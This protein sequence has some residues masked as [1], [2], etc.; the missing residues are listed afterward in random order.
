VERRVVKLLVLTFYYEPDLSAG[1]FRTTALVQ[2][3]LAAVPPG[4]TI[5]VVTTLPNR[6]RSFNADA[7][8][9]EQHGALTVRRIALPPHRSGMFDQSNSFLAFARGALA[10]TRG[11]RYELVFATSS[12]LMTAALGAWIA[13]R[14]RARLYLDIRDIFADTIKDVAPPLVASAM[15]P[16]FSMLE[17]WTITRAAK[18][19]LVS[20]GFAPYFDA[21]YPR[22]R[23]SYFTNG[24][25]DEF[26]AIAP[27]PTVG[28]VTD[29][30]RRGPLTVVYA[31]N[32][33]K[34]QGLHA[35]LPALAKRLEGRVRFRVIGDGGM[36][37]ALAAALA[38]ARVT[39]VELTAPV[40]REA[41]INAYRDADVLF[42]HLN[43]HDAFRKV[44]PSK[45]FEY[46]AMGKPIWAGVAGYAAGFIA[47]EVSN[48]A[49]FPP[50]N[51]EGAISAFESLHIGDS[52]RSEFLQRHA[53]S[54]ISRDLAADVIA[55][56]EAR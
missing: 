9:V 14:A 55:V 8:E 21:R 27:A 10:L 32:V 5:D 25:D 28:A 16:L 7:P 12:R 50:C 36:R 30:R 53:R 26:L 40:A 19:N 39:N 6:Y 38:A 48:A 49:I 4:S 52:P 34:G 47:G 2:S 56:G 18:V 13:R 29:G 45:L 51:V 37:P 41:L 11:Q 23:F 1:S 43:D 17:R 31:G 15:P 54:S 3:L 22:Q 44:L 46:A 24:V 33:G 35:I 42:L 20:R